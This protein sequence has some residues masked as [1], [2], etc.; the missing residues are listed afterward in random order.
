MDIRIRMIVIAQFFP[1]APV[2]VRTDAISPA[3]PNAEYKPGKGSE[4]KGDQMQFPGTWKNPASHIKQG[5]YG[6]KYKEEDIEEKVPHAVVTIG[7][8]RGNYIPDQI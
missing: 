3:V 7:I 5:K 8:S 2:P 4:W 1:H 6:M